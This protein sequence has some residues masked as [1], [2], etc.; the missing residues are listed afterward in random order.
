MPDII[1]LLPDSVSNQIAAGEV[2]QRP[3]SAIKELMENAVDAGATK[4]SVIVKDSGKSLIQVIDNGCGMS[5]TD[6]RLSFERHATSKIRKTDDLFAIMTMGFRG[7]A[8]ASIA[9]IA[10]VEL[11]SRRNEDEL[12]TLVLIEGNE[13]IS[14]EP[15]AVPEGTSFAI[16]NLFFNVPARRN[17]LKSNSLEARHIIDEF[18][19][20]AIAHPSIAMTLS[21]NGLETFNLPSTNLRQRLVSIFGTQYNERLVPVQEETSLLSVSGF[22]GKPEF[23]RKK[24][25]EQF[26]FVNHRF[27]RDAYLHHAVTNA[28]EELLPRE[29]YASYWLFIDMEPSRIDVNIHPTKTEIKFE[30]ERSVYAIIRSSVKR[31]LGQYSVTP[32]LDF[33]TEKNFDVPYAMRHQPPQKPSVTINTGYNPFERERVSLPV[34]NWEKLYEGLNSTPSQRIAQD[35]QNSAKHVLIPA[36]DQVKSILREENYFQ[37]NREFLVASSPDGLLIINQQAAHERI[38]FERFNREAQA[39]PAGS[40]Q[41]LFPQTLEYSASDSQLLTEL[42]PDLKSLGF[43]IRPFGLHTF[44]L[45]GTPSIIEQGSGKEVIDHLLES[46]RSDSAN[47]KLNVKEQLAKSLARNLAVRKGKI[48]EPA[49]I[50]ALISDLFDCEKSFYGI[51]GKPCTILLKTDELRNRLS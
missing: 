19:R 1:Q 38:L 47:V 20:I 10:H 12:G 9:S 40:Q 32:A 27:I 45:Q 25:G 21:M 11:K 18:E 41:D 23:A 34:T 17:F 33:E 5:P 36:D 15:C 6:A 28:F 22:I 43:D 2:I 49:E 44:I 14:Q 4:I 35:D 26:F 39:N 13:F 51:D 8:L 24:R 30:D 48:L 29:S 7:E 31:A 16:K 50:K 3:S 46:C 42:E 37:L